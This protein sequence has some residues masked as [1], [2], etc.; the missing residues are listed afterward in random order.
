MRHGWI[1]LLSLAWLFTETA[2]AQTGLPVPDA[3]FP[4][5]VGR[6]Y[7]ESDPPLYPRPV[8]PPAGAPNI[9]VVVLDDVGFGQYQTFGGAVPSPSLD[10]LAAEGLRFNRFHTA[11]ICSPTRAALLTGRNPHRAGFGLVGELATGYDGYVG[12]LP[13]STATV[14]EVLRLNG[15]ATAMFGK[16]HNTPNWEGGPA[17]PF[18]HWPTGF[19]FDYFYGFNGWG[20]SQWNPV[21]YENT[22]PVV[23]PHRPGL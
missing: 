12:F 19:G 18:T 6:T 10:A 14:A 9:V 5:K 11:G 23:L 1:V 8:R 20:T 22:R 4:G 15:Y 16:N 17:G 3:T 2:A 13:R 7:K 21:L